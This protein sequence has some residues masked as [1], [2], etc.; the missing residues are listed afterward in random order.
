MKWLGEAVWAE[1]TK[2]LPAAWQK[3]GRSFLQEFVSFRF[4]SYIVIQ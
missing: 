2:G 1:G 3:A 4:Y